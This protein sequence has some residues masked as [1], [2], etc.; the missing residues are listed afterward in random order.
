MT[1]TMYQDLL[2]FISESSSML[3]NFDMKPDNVMMGPRLKA[4]ADQGHEWLRKQSHL[5]SNLTVKNFQTVIIMILFG[6]LAKQHLALKSVRMELEETSPMAAAVLN[7]K[8]LST[9]VSPA[10]IQKDNKPTTAFPDQGGCPVLDLKKK[11]INLEASNKNFAS[12]LA[13]TMLDRHNWMSQ[14]MQQGQQLRDLQRAHEELVEAIKAS[15]GLVG[16]VPPPIVGGL[17]E[18]VE[19]H[20]LSLNVTLPALDE[21]PFEWDNVPVPKPARIPSAAMIPV[22]PTSM[23]A[24]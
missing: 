20:G 21:K 22:G 2:D 3:R 5:K 19:P 8:D 14:A 18:Y 1:D 17:E 9:V 16:Y 13:F 23:V 15:K 12:E 10:P 11:I 7:Q 6:M 4:M 24:V